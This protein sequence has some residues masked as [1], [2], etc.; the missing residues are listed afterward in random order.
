MKEY[1]KGKFI[2]VCVCTSLQISYDA[3][4]YEI[5]WSL[6]GLNS[7]IFLLLRTSG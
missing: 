4:G 7:N 5:V 2:D 6:Y 3:L 1:S